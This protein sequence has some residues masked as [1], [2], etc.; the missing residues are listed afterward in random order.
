MGSI[1]TRS[2]TP[3]PVPAAVTAR[4]IAED[5]VPALAELRGPDCYPVCTIGVTVPGHAPF[6]VQGW[7]VWCDGRHYGG[8]AEKSWHTTDQADHGEPRVYVAEDDATTVVVQAGD[9][10]DGTRR[11]A[12]ATAAEALEMATEILD[13]VEAVYNDWTPE[14]PDDDELVEALRS[15]GHKIRIEIEVPT[16]DDDGDETTETVE[17]TLYA[18][19]HA[20]DWVFAVEDDD[21]LYTDCDDAVESLV[22]LLSDRLDLVEADEG[23][24]VE[25]SASAALKGAS[26][27]AVAE[28]RRLLERD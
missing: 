6:T 15:R 9:N 8:S 1:P 10:V 7:K 11:L 21:E 4:I 18:D 25:W 3:A 14:L 24:E 26:A 22:A 5:A 2:E 19:T 27:D 23:R 20:G 28:V 13:A 16:L 12:F 17:A